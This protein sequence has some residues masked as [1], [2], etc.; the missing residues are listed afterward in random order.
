[1]LVFKCDGCGL[2]SEKQ[3]RRHHL[4]VERK[5]IRIEIFKDDREIESLDYCE[6]CLKALLARWISSS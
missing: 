5:H 6:D 4:K 2:V 1:M 3:L